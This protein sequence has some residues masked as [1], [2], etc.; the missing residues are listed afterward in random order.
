MESLEPR[1]MLT[2]S[3][4]TIVGISDIISEGESGFFIEGEANDP[5]GT[6]VEVIYSLNSTFG[7]SDDLVFN[8]NPGNPNQL[9]PHPFLPG[10][11]LA[12]GFFSWTV[13]SAHGIV[14]DG[15]ATYPLYVQVKDNS[16]NFIIDTGTLEILN[17]L[18]TISDLEITPDTSGCGSLTVH[19]TATLND[20]GPVDGLFYLVDWGDDPDFSIF[21]PPVPAGT[22]SPVDGSL[23][24]NVSHT[25]AAPG[26]YAVTLYVFDDDGALEYVEGTVTVTGTGGG[27]PP[28]LTVAPLFTVN[29]GQNATLSATVTGTPGQTVALAWDLVSAVSSPLEPSTTLTLDGS[30]SA[31]WNV[32]VP[33]S[34]LVSLGIADSHGGGT[35]AITLQATSSGGCS[36][37]ASAS[38]SLKVNNVAPTLLGLVLT[39]SIIGGPQVTLDGNFTDPGIGDDPFTVVVTWES[40]VSEV[41]P[42]VAFGTVYTFT[43]THTYTSAGAKT[44][45]VSMTDD[46]GATGTGSTSLAVR[47]ALAPDGTLSVAGSSDGD[48]FIITRVGGNLVRVQSDLLEEPVDFPA[49]AVSAIVADLGDGN[50]FLLIAATLTQ[51][52]VVLGGAGN[53]ILIGGG[54]RDILIGGTGTDVIHGRS[55]QDILVGGATIHDANVTALL[56]LLAEWNSE[57]S[58][59]DRVLNLKNGSGSVAG[60]NGSYFLTLVGNDN[61]VDFLVGGS[62]TDWIWYHIGDV[63]VSPD[64]LLNLV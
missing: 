6:V 14:N 40:G 19:L 33:W 43:V 32:T 37:T 52:A 28:G 5:D 45:S 62:G 18:P 3:L 34:S 53:D 23:N 31:T 42:V 56:A 39:Q 60:L 50:D 57:H 17:E 2:G 13:L 46:E 41:V 55:N 49:A 4:P 21:D 36:G 58:L 61:A 47:A 38:S 27:T 10:Y 24:L 22:R 44:I 30:G 7:D 59:L 51:P 63:V 48:N 54:G 26:T 64:D 25:Y 15:P 29:E 11:Y 1:A 16:G 20:P 8:Q 35:Y 12:Y 9:E